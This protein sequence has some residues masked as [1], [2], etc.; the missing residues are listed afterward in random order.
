[1]RAF[2]TGGAGFIG[3]HLSEDLLQRGYE[4]RI[5]DDLSSG[6][7]D[8]LR[9]LKGRPGF[10][11]TV[12]SIFDAPLLAELI[13]EADLVF[14]LAAAVGVKMIVDR[15]V[16]T[17][18]T[19]VHGTESILHVADKKKKPVLIASTSE[20]YGKSDR[21]PFREDDDVVLGPTVK[22]R[23]SYACSKLIDE[24]LA[25]SYARSR[26][27]PVVIARLFNT[28]GPRQTGRYG[29][30]IPRFIDQALNDRPI[31]VYDDGRQVRCFAHVA[32][33][34]PILVDLLQTPAAH[35]RIFN[36]GNDREITILEL[37]ERVRAKIPGAPPIR[38]VPYSEAY[39]S[40]FEDLRRRVPDLTRLRSLL[41]AR[42]MRDIDVILDD[43]IAAERERRSLSRNAPCPSP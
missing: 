21:I 7:M 35:G 25:L 26:G 40:G 37:A 32:D 18:Q 2:I 20:V 11:Y 8:N 33:V 30:V 42:P 22:S 43:T 19:N 12:G 5:L 27:L 4:V 14:H 9:R 15:P 24:F 29:M 31:T 34:A 16:E 23:W 17:I 41:G 38:H 6:S 36:V 10:S 39:E 13:D 3:S 28:V 1:V